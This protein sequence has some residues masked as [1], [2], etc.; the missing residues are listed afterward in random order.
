[1][2][3][4][5]L[6]GGRGVLFTILASRPQ[7][8]QIAVLDLKTRQRKTLIRGGTDAKYVVGRLTSGCGISRA[9]R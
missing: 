6:P 5:M 4:S 7:N 2:F 3:P 1:M 8:A 9:R